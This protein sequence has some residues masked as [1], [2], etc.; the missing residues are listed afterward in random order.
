[1]PYVAVQPAEAAVQLGLSYAGDV[2]E[3]ERRLA[4]AR[5]ALH[6]ARAQR[7]RPSLDDKV[8]VG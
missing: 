8:G 4:G 2:R 6:R 3:V 5:E 1:M 7:P